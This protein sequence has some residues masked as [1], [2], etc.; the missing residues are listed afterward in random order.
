MRFQKLKS[1]L[2]LVLVSVAGFARGES[3]SQIP[4]AF[5]YDSMISHTI[6]FPLGGG[7][8]QEFTFRGYDNFQL[9]ETTAISNVAWQGIYVDL[10]NP[11]NNPAPPSAQSFGIYLHSNNAGVP[12]AVL[13]GATLNVANV[14]QT[15]LTNRQYSLDGSPVTAP[16]YSYSATLPT[17]FVA[18]ANTVYWLTVH[19]ISYD[20][21]LPEIPPLP[22]WG[23]NNSSFGDHRSLQTNN[24]GFGD[25]EF[26][27]DRTFSISPA[28]AGHPGDFDGDGD[29]DG[30]DFVVWQTNFPAAGGH[31]LNTGDAD[32]DGDVDGADFVVWQTNFPYMPSGAVAVPEGSSLTMSYWALGSALAALL[33]SRTARSRL[34][35]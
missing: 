14:Q 12:G 32:G 23:W 17:P 11:A 21:G 3:Y 20:S 9:N 34:G 31:A 19:A 28:A 7:S 8:Y 25:R 33:R 35:V 1:A 24:L 2:L 27:Y 16:V 4:E 22:F 18:Q 26:N 29:V 5:D 10:N 30:A 13:G 15:F 6:F